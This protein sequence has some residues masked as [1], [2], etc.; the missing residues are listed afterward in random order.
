M[1]PRH[2]KEDEAGDLE[3]MWPAAMATLAIG[4]IY[5]AMPPAILL[6]P[7]WLLPSL[8]AVLLLPAIV[9]HHHPLMHRVLGY[10]LAGIVT[11]FMAAS[12][13]RLILALPDRTVLPSSLL[14]SGA[15]LWMT[16]VLVFASWYWRL[17]AGGPHGRAKRKGHST[18]AFLFPQM[19]AG[20]GGDDRA[21]TP[22]FVDY[23]FLAF[24]TSTAFSPTDTAVLLRWAKVLMMV[25][26]LISLM[27][28]GILI[29]RAVNIL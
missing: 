14:R 4:C 12:V 1:E 10:S 23:L 8:V 21:W 25:Q 18:G 29:G 6:G 20:S 13:V 9:L 26:S 28:I 7:R 2:N 16:N 17:D 5:L 27:V 15:V 3:P 24:N 19:T 11:F 22:R